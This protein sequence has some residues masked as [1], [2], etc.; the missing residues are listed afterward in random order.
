MCVTYPC[1][2]SY[3]E[4]HSNPVTQTQMG[5]PILV[6]NMGPSELSQ[7]N[8]TSLVEYKGAQKLNKAI[9]AALFVYPKL[10]D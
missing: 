4:G 8:R 6:P 2:A 10:V 3:L 9:L 7:D 1:F 5:V